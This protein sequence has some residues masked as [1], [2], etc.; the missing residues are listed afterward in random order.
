MRKFKIEQHRI[1]VR[2][3]EFHFVSY[4]GQDANPKK[5]LPAKPPTWYLMSAGRRW[6]VM[7]HT[8]NQDSEELE[9]LFVDWVE[10]NVFAQNT[11][12]GG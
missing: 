5:N 3:R 10:R 4:E 12:T 6:E 2:G 1:T 9:Q 7:R 11:G 8:P